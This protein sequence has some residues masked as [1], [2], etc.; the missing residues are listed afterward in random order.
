MDSTLWILA[1][2]LTQGK[3]RHAVRRM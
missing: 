1:A 3:H 2:T